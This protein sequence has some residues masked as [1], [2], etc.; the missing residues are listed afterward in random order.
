MDSSRLIRTVACFVAGLVIAVGSALIYSLAH[1]LKQPAEI[2]Q[3]TPPHVQ[4]HP[5]TS[6]PLP[7]T[8]NV[9][10]PGVPVVVPSQRA[11]ISEAA[12]R[13]K[14][15]ARVRTTTSVAK[16]R[17]RIRDRS[18][19]I[20]GQA[21]T[22]VRPSLQAAKSPQSV[23][24]VQIPPAQSHEVTLEPGIPITIQLV[25]KL[26]TDY[27]N[28]GDTF[29]AVLA[30]PVVASGFVVADTGSSVLGRIEY[31]RRARLLG[32]EPELLLTVTEIGTSDGQMIA[33]RT[34]SC[35]ETGA[36]KGV[37]SE[38][39]MRAGVAV[40]AI[41]RAV[42]RRVRAAGFT[43]G[44]DDN[45]PLDQGKSGERWSVVLPV[46]TKLTFHVATPLLIA[47]N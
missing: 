27:N 20:I 46:G 19:K 28:S 6:K 13:P 44:L 26:S 17:P 42:S 35:E 21:P 10:K 15:K 12:P 4:P 3:I 11:S 16:A 18:P 41:L 47:N 37:R 9:V 43:S 33:V 31:A 40:G 29:R 23:V 22:V 38:V 8:G 32:A 34:D 1:G 7:S 5:M 39:K 30:E 25:E 24:A 14:P 36:R 45:F 2:A